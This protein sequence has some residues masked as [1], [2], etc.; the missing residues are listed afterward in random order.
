MKV[1]H[2]VVVQEP[3]KN[4]TKQCAAQAQ[5]L[6]CFFFLTS[7]F[8]DVLCATVVV[9]GNLKL[10]VKSVL[11]PWLGPNQTHFPFV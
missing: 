6:F 7:R 4:R 2:A 9:F 1:F 11:P 3:T 5:L 8:F 10:P